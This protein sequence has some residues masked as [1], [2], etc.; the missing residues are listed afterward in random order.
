[1]VGKI[2]MTLKEAGFADEVKKKRGKKIHLEM[3]DVGSGFR[4][5]RGPDP[6]AR[7]QEGLTSPRRRGASRIGFKR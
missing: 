5:H 3:K 2:Q 7:P 6:E 4:G 1:M